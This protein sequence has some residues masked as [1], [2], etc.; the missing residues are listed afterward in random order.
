MQVDFT[1]L[2]PEFMLAGL[3]VLVLVVDFSVPWASR[4]A[5]NGVLAALT[6]LGLA[7]T[8]VVTL[9][10]Q[11]DTHEILYEHLI[12]VDRYA[13]LFK[14]LAMAIGAAVVLI[15]MEYVHTRIRHAG[16]FYALI[17]FAVL[18]AVLMAGA[19]ELLTAYIAIELLAFCLYVLVAL[20][21]GDSRSGE[22][23]VKYI[24]LGA[25]SSAVMLFGIALI[26]GAIGETGF[27]RSELLL[28][29]VF[30]PT[31]AL[32]LGMFVAGLGFKLSMAPFHLWAPD[33]YEGAPTPVTALVS[34]LSK[35]A[36]FALT[37]R[38]LAEAGNATLGEWQLALAILAALTMTVGT[39]TALVQ[40]NIKRLLAYSSVAQVG[41]VL[42][43]IIALNESG[44]RAALLHIAGYSFT[45]LA[46][47]AVVIAVEAKTGKERISDYA[48]LA[49]R[50]PFLAMVMS[51]AMFSLA[52]LPIFA[53][54]VTKFL[55]FT[56]AVEGGLFWL[57]VIA[58]VNSLVSLY[59]YLR[60]VRE[61]YVGEA[62]ETGRLR[63][64]V[65]ASVPVW[66]LFAG[67]VF[68]GIYPA[69]LMDAAGAAVGALAPF[70]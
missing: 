2:I 33:V 7:V 50:S 9:W 20:S 37:L 56:S 41:F 38:F 21:R 44:A 47:F 40:E 11:W 1:L 69:P 53:G 36:A 42:I 3:G 34:V 48:G 29:A 32:G 49:S 14:A 62:A 67:T 24:L 16:E 68:V 19:A 23:A 31:V 46:A 57:M 59:Y 51:A 39:F 66:F 22:A 8:F 17:V 43:G 13:L 15:S 28:E 54:F 58:V 52:G 70:L 61:M 27:R 35:A 30:G 4:G 5:K 64:H 6:V 60:I 18:G 63:L 55:L 10:M 65:A 12:Y 26:Y 25:I 45:N